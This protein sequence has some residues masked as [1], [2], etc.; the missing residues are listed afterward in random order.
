M[1]IDYQAVKPDHAGKVLDFLATIHEE[2]LLTLNRM[3]KLP[4]EERERE[5]LK[6][7]DGGKGFGMVARIED[8]IV[9]FLHAEILQPKE[10]S[11]NCEFGLSILADYRRQGIGSYLIQQAEDWAWAKG[12]FRMELGVYS[13][14]AGGIQLYEKLGYHEDGRRVNAVKLWN[15][16]LADII[17]MYK[18]LNDPK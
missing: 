11:V 6:K 10:M 13:N 3:T 1:R 5:W 2:K 17:H 9:G 14:N 7:F 4:S 8:R 15:G 16:E 12:A 18:F